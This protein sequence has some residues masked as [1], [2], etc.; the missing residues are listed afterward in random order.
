[1]RNILLVLFGFIGK[2]RMAKIGGFLS[3]FFVG[4]EG[5]KLRSV[6]SVAARR[7]PFAK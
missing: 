2:K 7:L 1:M 5:Q 3:G 4:R 6:G